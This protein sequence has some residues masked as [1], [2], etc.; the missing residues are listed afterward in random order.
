V[1]T[2]CIPPKANAEF[3]YH[4]EDVLRVEQLPDDRRSPVVWMDE[5]SQQWLG[6][7][8]APLPLRAGQVK[9]ADYA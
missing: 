1:K 8:N 2:W 9:C 6:E 5:A 4:M 3:V 7:V